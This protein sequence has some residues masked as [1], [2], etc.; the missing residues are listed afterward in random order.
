[1]RIASFSISTRYVPTILGRLPPIST[2]P[3][4]TA[5]AAWTAER[6]IGP[7]KNL[8]SDS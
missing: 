4:L 3:F 8:E 6:T 5:D 1:M 2:D 7:S